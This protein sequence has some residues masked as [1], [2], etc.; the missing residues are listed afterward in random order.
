MAQYIA[1]T[2]LIVK[3]YDEAIDFYVNSLGFDLI[4]D[5][6]QPDPHIP[7]NGKRWVVVA[8]P[9]SQTRLLL[10][11]AVTEEQKA[12]IGNQTGG[13]VFM[14]LYTDD[15]WRDYNAY[16]SKGVSFVRGEPRE[17]SYG[18][19]A[20]FLDVYGNMWDLIQPAA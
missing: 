12:H 14:F 17:E 11:K 20:V 2:A 1:Q 16:S 7:E 3:D 18:T 8:P 19:V 15:F 5:T 6:P 13:R 10:S 4:E 9:G